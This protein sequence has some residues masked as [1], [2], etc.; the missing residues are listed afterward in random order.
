MP[1]I[2]PI[3]ANSSQPRLLNPASLGPVCRRTQGNRD[4]SELNVQAAPSGPTFTQTPLPC[5]PDPEPDWAGAVAE[6][7]PAGADAGAYD[8]D[9]DSG[10]EQERDRPAGQHHDRHRAAGRMQP[11][12]TGRPADAGP[13]PAG[14]Q[15]EGQLPGGHAVDQVDR[16]PAAITLGGGV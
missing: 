8:V 3:A 1:Q 7:V 14:G 16:G 5:E 10:E 4:R 2:T 9:R 12:D 6:G 13:D 15:R 11:Q